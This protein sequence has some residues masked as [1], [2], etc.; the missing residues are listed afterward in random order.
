[1]QFVDYK[2]TTELNEQFAQRVASLLAAAIAKKGKAS[3]VVSGGRTPLPFFQQLSQ[4]DIEWNKVAITLADERWVEQSS[5]AS[6]TALVLN[7]LIQNKASEATFVELKTSET[8][9]FGAEPSVSANLEKLSF[10]I[11]VLILGMGEDGH[12]ASLFP[13]SEQIE[14]GLTSDAV[15]LA[16]QPTTAPHERMSLTLKALL[17]SE[18]IFVHLV[19]ES[20]KVVLDKALAGNDVKEMPIRA[21][22]KQDSTPVDVIWAEK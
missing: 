18:Q 13:C 2:N 4:A 7:N 12:T 11:D 9:A 8:S 20:K 6:N 14:Q 10:P 3:L 15:C 17:N 1:M 5:D 21:I 16:V 22:L 19:G